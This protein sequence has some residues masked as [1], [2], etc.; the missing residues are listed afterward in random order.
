[1][2][3]CIDTVHAVHL[4]YVQYVQLPTEVLEGIWKC[5]DEVNG[6]QCAGSYILCWR[7]DY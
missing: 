4:V 3:D 1:M 5:F 2:A 6:Q 7:H